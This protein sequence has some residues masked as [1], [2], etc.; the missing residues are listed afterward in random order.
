M[1]K[2]MWRKPQNEIRRIVAFG[3]TARE[4]LVLGLAVGAGALS[5]FLLAPIVGK[6]MVIYIS[7]FIAF[8]IG[9]GILGRY[10]NMTLFEFFNRKYMRKTV[11]VL[12]FG[13]IPVRKERIRI[14]NEKGKSKVKVT[15]PVQET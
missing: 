2:Y 7:F 4:L 15:R 13:S 1:A 8:V 9:Y 11:R 5:Y 10:Q 14:R 6:D 12:T 3:M